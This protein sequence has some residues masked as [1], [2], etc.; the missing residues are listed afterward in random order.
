M[1]SQIVAQ[2]RYRW[3]SH[4]VCVLILKCRTP[5]ASSPTPPRGGAKGRGAVRGEEWV[6]RPLLGRRKGGPGPGVVLGRASRRCHPCFS[7]YR[8]PARGVGAPPVCCRPPRASHVSWGP[9]ALASARAAR[10]GPRPR[11]ARQGRSRVQ[12]GSPRHGPGPSQ[13]FSFSR[14]PPRRDSR[15][16]AGSAHGA[17][18]GTGACSTGGS[19][20][21]PTSTSRSRRRSGASSGPT[22]PVAAAAA[23]VGCSAGSA[24]RR[25]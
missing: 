12:G 13:S 6:R 23:P 19:T 14:R 22:C 20:R 3:L 2:Q 8:K 1:R 7:P 11:P 9:P 16:R 18:G 21:P 10:P 17:P 24:T 25:A 15:P 5:K 4:S